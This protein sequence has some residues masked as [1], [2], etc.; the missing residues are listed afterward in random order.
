MTTFE[1]IKSLLEPQQWT[2][3]LIIGVSLLIF[4]G[5]MI[6]AKEEK[7]PCRKK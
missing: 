4:V 5:M 1:T 3:L 7:K 2:G 6:D